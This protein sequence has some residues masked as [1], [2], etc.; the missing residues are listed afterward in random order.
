MLLVTSLFILLF[1]AHLLGNLSL[2]LKQPALAGHMIAG[3]LIGPSLLGWL[4]PTPALS[5]VANIAVLF[6]V[7]S[8]GLEMRLQHVL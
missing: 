8:A 6:V 1:A 3:I 2:R 4:L 5:A 7:L